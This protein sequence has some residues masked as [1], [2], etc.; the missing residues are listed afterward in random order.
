MRRTNVRMTNN[1]DPDPKVAAK[2]PD[3][4]S[5]VIASTWMHDDEPVQCLRVGYEALR[6]GLGPYSIFS[7]CSYPFIPS[8]YSIHP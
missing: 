3:L 4:T 5:K 8:E 7:V 1:R 6:V 2:D